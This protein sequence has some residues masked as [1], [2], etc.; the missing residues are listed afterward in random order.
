MVSVNDAVDENAV[1]QRA[2]RIK[3][4][5]KQLSENTLKMNK[6]KKSNKL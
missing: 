4:L 5:E 6:I 3:M 1:K 2:T